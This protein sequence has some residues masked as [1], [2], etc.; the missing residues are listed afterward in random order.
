MVFE[1]ILKIELKVKDELKTNGCTLYKT[2]N[3]PVSPFPG[4]NI[5]EDN[6]ICVDDL[7]YTVETIYCSCN[8]YNPKV[9]CHC[10]TM[11]FE[12]LKELEKCLELLYKLK[13][14]E[15]KKNEE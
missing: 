15:N 14:S 3:L 9:S 12:T 10:K 6:F 7:Q 8:P 1:V 11:F 4:L 2:I 5:Y 13:W